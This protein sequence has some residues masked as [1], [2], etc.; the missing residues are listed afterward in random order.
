MRT[1]TFSVRRSW[2]L[3]VAGA[4]MVA[5]LWAARVSA[6]DGKDYPQTPPAAGLNLMKQADVDLVQGKWRYS[7]TKIIEV[8][9]KG[10]DGKPNKTY[11]YTPHAG[12]KD[13]DDSQWEVLD[14][15]TLGKPRSTGKLCFNWYRINVTI[16]EKVGDFS[17]AGSTAVFETIVD[18]YGEV[19]VDGKLPRTVGQAGGSIVKG[20]NAP[21]RLVVGKNVQ[22]GQKIQIAVFGINSP[23]SDTPGNWIFLRNAKLDFYKP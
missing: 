13:F 20:F 17:T 8:D 21:N 18:D 6:Q 10:P 16:P 14:P 1:E 5:G 4:A 3:A 2:L 12:G 9:Y 11:D 15:A 19:W 23:L 22:P 7:D